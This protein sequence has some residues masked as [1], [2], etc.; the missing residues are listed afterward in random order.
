MPTT[1]CDDNDASVLSSSLWY[2]DADRDGYAT[3]ETVTSC[4][5]PGTGYT[6]NQL[7]T[8]DCDDSDVMINPD[9]IWYLDAD[10]D[11]FSEGDTIVG[12]LSP[13]QDYTTE[14]LLP[15]INLT[16]AKIVLFPNPT[17]DWITILLAEEFKQLDVTIVN[18]TE[19]L[20]LKKAFNNT[21]EINLDLSHQSSGVYFI[22]ISI[23][24]RSNY[25]LQVVRE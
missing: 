24:G 3:E 22:N 20:V 10:S 6:T 9:T 1:D 23:D 11:G 16:G 19:Q 5:N 4:T 13:G 2:L 12:C 17:T 18:A 25:A 8:T 7:P 21:Q 15:Q 14:E